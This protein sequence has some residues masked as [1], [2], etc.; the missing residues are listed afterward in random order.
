MILTFIALFFFHILKGSHDPSTPE[1]IDK[2]EKE[3]NLFVSISPDDRTGTEFE[4]MDKLIDDY[5]SDTNSKNSN[6]HSNDSSKKTE[7]IDNIEKDKRSLSQ[8]EEREHKDKCQIPSI[9]KNEDKA[10][11]SKS[12]SAYIRSTES[13]AD[14]SKLT[15]VYVRGT[16]SNVD[17][18]GSTNK[19]P[20]P[21]TAPINVSKV[22]NIS[23]GEEYLLPLVILSFITQ[24][25]IFHLEG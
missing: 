3:I 4:W 5:I 19:K 12:T 11:E 15:S 14:E 20:I 25:L 2:R 17:S 22:V 23:E 8:I 24:L 7:N 16:E 9:I 6:S 10:V 1:H 13:N 21:E 18:N